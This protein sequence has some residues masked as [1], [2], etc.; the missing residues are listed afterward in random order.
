MLTELI[1]GGVLNALPPAHVAALL[2]CFLGLDSS[3]D[4][5]QLAT[6]L[7]EPISFAKETMQKLV[8]AE[9]DARMEVRGCSSAILVGPILQ[10]A[11]LRS[12]R[13]PQRRSQQLRQS[14]AAPCAS[15]VAFERT[16]RLSAACPRAAGQRGV[17]RG[18]MHLRVCLKR[19]SYVI[20]LHA[21]FWMLPVRH[22][23]TRR[24]I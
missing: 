2:S 14:V 23:L 17:P 19:S 8:E 22:R 24:S 4:V 3:K 18:S 12:F 6:Q 20:V 1:F 21:A 15:T 7:R 13:S 5:V 10:P 11:S 9:R 16:A